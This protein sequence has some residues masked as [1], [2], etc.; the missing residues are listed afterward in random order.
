MRAPFLLSLAWRDLRASG[1]TLW[2]FCACL[3][4][5][6]ALISAGGGLYGHVVGGLQNQARALYG[7][8]LSIRL[9]RAVP[10]AEMA[11]LRSRGTVSQAVE[12]RTMLLNSAGRSQLVE[13]Q[14]VDSHY[15]LVGRLTLAPADAN[16]TPMP[17][18]LGLHNGRWGAALDALLA[19]RLGL[20]VGDLVKVGDA[21]LEVRATVL[22][23]PDRSLRAD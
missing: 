20:A 3:A 11:W 21:T 4:L 19:R 5:G 23:Q 15:P 2:V 12:L 16:D 22:H 8:D 1:R 14:T 18:L 10:A 7:G 9:D 13:L 6:V 17:H